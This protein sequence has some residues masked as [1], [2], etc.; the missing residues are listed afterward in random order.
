[1]FRIYRPDRHWDDPANE[2]AVKTRI[3]VLLCP[4]ADQGREGLEYT[5]FTSAT[6]RFYLYGAPTDY[7]N[8]GGLGTALTASLSPPPADNTGVLGERP[9]KV[10]DITDG[11]S[12]TML[13]TE[14]AIDRNCGSDGNGSV[15]PPPVP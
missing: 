2:I 4:T 7:T 13:V 9:L 11:L 3:K 6:P 14:C 5:R 15:P 8:V 12:N 10:L 1:V